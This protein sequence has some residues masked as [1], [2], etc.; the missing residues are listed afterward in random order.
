MFFDRLTKGFTNV[1]KRKGG[2]YTPSRSTR[3]RNGHEL[4]QVNLKKIGKIITLNN[5][6]IDRKGIIVY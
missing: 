1:T 4:K 3:C 6:K 5:T 2:R